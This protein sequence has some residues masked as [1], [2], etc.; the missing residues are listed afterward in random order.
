MKKDIKKI[1]YIKTEYRGYTYVILA[2]VYTEPA[3]KSVISL[4]LRAIKDAAVEVTDA[5]S[6]EE[7]KDGKGKSPAKIQDTIKLK[8]YKKEIEHAE[9]PA[10]KDLT[11][12]IGNT[13]LKKD[14]GED[15][16]EKKDKK[17][18]EEEKEEEE[19]DTKKKD[20]NKTK[21]GKKG[22]KTTVTK[23]KKGKSSRGGSRKHS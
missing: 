14:K 21:G 20:T 16:E 9:D 17:K 23:P 3:D 7:E 13:G 19:E 11:D 12:K 5:S 2:M 6:S 15:T 18:K 8:A 1:K 10:V 22:H 4:G